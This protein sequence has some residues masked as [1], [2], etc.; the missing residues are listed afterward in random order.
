MQYPSRDESVLHL[1]LIR[2]LFSEK[3]PSVTTPNMNRETDSTQ[4]TSRK[5]GGG[6]DTQWDNHSKAFLCRNLIDS[7][8]FIQTMVSLI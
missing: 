8:K 6:I 2:R 3:P 7:D 4:T 5:K 1:S